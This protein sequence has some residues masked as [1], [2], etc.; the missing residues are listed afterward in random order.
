MGAMSVGGSRFSSVLHCRESSSGGLRLREHGVPSWV[1]VSALA[2]AGCARG[3]PGGSR[4]KT[5]RLHRTPAGLTT[6]ALDG[7]GLRGHWPTRPTE[8]G[9][10]PGSCPSSGRGFAPRFLQ[11]PSRDDAF[12]LR[13]SFAAIG[14]DGGL[15]PPS[16]WSCSA[17]EKGAALS[18][19]P[20][21]TSSAL[22]FSRG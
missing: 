20:L 1:L 18:S 15:A 6:P 19:R 10:V 13:S 21:R 5:D 16:G 12:A 17:H 3:P 7:C 2:R 9:L 11:T 4:G 22:L 14:L 8:A